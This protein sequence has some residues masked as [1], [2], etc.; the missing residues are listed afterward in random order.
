MFALAI[1]S[2]TERHSICFFFAPRENM[3]EWSCLSKWLAFVVTGWLAVDFLHLMANC[4]LFVRN[5]YLAPATFLFRQIDFCIHL[6]Q[7]GRLTFVKGTSF[8]F[9]PPSNPAE[10]A[11]AAS[12]TNEAAHPVMEFEELGLGFEFGFG[13]RLWLRLNSSN[14]VMWQCRSNGAATV[15]QT[16]RRN[17]SNQGNRSS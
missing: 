5:I 6:R 2:G 4:I 15:Q 16:N 12:L 11:T 1:V 10:A 14:V 17:P 7:A 8:H 9:L 13:L 3:L